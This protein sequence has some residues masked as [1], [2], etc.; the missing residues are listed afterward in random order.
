MEEE[1]AEELIAVEAEPGDEEVWAEELPVEAAESSDGEGGGSD[2]I[3]ADEEIYTLYLEDEVPAE[4]AGDGSDGEEELPADEEIYTTYIDE[5]EVPA[6]EGPGE[7]PG[8]LEDPVV[9]EG[10]TE[11]V[12]GEGKEIGSVDGEI[13]YIGG[14]WDELLYPTMN[15]GEWAYTTSAGGIDD[16]RIYMSSGSGPAPNERG[17]EAAQVVEVATWHTVNLVHHALVA[18]LAPREHIA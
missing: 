17:E 8:N 4:D 5:G 1:L 15:E 16:P 9:D 2:E 7:D 14:G 11:V 12:D 3:P 10:G 6:D 13:D 18:D